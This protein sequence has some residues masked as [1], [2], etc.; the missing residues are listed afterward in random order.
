M[1]AAVAAVD[2]GPLGDRLLA[3]VDSPGFAP[4]AL[5]VAFGAG[6]LHA[7]APG[8][9]KSLAAA[10]LIGSDG[11]RRDAL[12]L[13]GTVAAMHT[14]SV[15]AIGLTW[16]ALSAGAAAADTGALSQVLQVVAALLVVAAGVLLVRRRHGHDHHVHHHHDQQH[17]G[18][19]P[20]L[21]LLG[22]SGGLLPSPSAFL[23][24]L[25]GL[26]SGRTGLALLLV[27]VFGLGMAVVLTFIGLL[28]VTGRDLVASAAPTSASLRRVALVGPAIAAWGVLAAGCALTAAA[29]VTG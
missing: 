24:L 6:V 19:R 2:L 12:L 20:G 28:A 29:V 9:G 16:T 15:L 17:R 21:V 11:R 3:A 23:V 25:T 26:F 13:G 10:Y 7:L 5:A 18:E 1:G 8:H 22:A 27:A 4:T 14:A